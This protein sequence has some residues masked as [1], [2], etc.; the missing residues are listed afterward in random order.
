[1]DPTFDA[2]FDYEFVDGH[3]NKE[4]VFN[5]KPSR[6]LIEADLIFNMPATEQYSKMGVRAD[7][8]LL[9]R[10]WTALNGTKGPATWQKRF[11]W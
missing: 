10:I 3:M 4:L 8:G 5:H 11:I 2:E 9:T 1:M 7:E 6:T